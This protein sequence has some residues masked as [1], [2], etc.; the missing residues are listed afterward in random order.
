MFELLDNIECCEKRITILIERAYLTGTSGDS[1]VDDKASYVFA[2][3]ISSRVMSKPFDVFQFSVT[4]QWLIQ[5]R[6]PPLSLDETEA[7][8]AEKSKAAPPPYLRV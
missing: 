6:G 5:R 4:T 1:P 7:Q 8:K 2:S 3:V